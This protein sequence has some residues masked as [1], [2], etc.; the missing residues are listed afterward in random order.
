M[1]KDKAPEA[2]R[3]EEELSACPKCGAGRGFH[4]SFL[5]KE[6]RSLAVVLVCPSCGFR[7]TVGEW[8]FPTGE[9]RPYDPSIDSGP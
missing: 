4:V 9:P 8:S 7:F 1:E 3:M 2:I 6:G 5:R